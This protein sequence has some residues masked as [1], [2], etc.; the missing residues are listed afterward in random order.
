[1]PK[2]SEEEVARHGRR[3]M[4]KFNG[5]E[6]AKQLTI[7]ARQLVESLIEGKL[8]EAELKA[9]QEALERGDRSLDREILGR[10]TR[11]GMDLK[12]EPPLFS[13]LDALYAALDQSDKPVTE[14]ED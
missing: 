14:A 9:A 6:F 1:M 11:K 3:W 7:T 12:D 10:L 5:I 13:D 4:L 2:Y 8:S